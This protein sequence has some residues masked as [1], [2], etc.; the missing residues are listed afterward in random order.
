M[1]MILRVE[2][3][4]LIPGRGE[5][6]ADAG[7]LVDD[8]TITYL[9]FR[10]GAFDRDGAPLLFLVDSEG[11]VHLAD[12]QVDGAVLRVP[13]LFEEAILLTEGDPTR[14]RTP[15]LVIERR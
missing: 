7:V 12:Y 13:T 3:P 10:E 15:R 11:E 14:R 4:T 6:I 5:P 8:G 1:G 2:T 9:I